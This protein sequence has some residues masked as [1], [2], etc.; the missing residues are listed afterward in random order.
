MLNNHPNHNIGLTQRVIHGG[1]W[2]LGLRGVSFSISL[3]KTF[4]LARILMPKDF[5]VMGVAMIAFSTVET[6]SQTGIQSALIQKKENIESYLNTAWTIS[7]IRGGVLFLLLFSTSYYFA[8]FFNAPETTQIIKIISIS[9]LIS[10]ITNIGVIYFQKELQFNKQFIYEIIASIVDIIIV[11]P[12][13]F[14]LKSAWALAISFIISSASKLIVSY[15]LCSY[16]PRIQ[17]EILKVRKLFQYGRWVSLS[18]VIVYLIMQGDNIFIS[19]IF[20]TAALGYYAMAYRI[21]NLPATEINRVIS[22]V[23]FPAYSKI[24]NDKKAFKEGFKKTLQIISFII[25]PLAGSIFVFSKE[26]TIV[27]LGK[28]WQMIIPIIQILCFFGV[29][30]AIN[31]TMGPALLAAGRPQTLSFVSLIQL[32]IM[33]II[34]YP[35]GIK[36]GI[37]GV[38]WA[39]TIANFVAFVIIYLQTTRL[40]SISTMEFLQKIYLS[41][42]IT[43]IT[44]GLIFLL[45]LCNLDILQNN[46]VI[47]LII[48]GFLFYVLY[49][50]LGFLFNKFFKF[51]LEDVLSKNPLKVQEK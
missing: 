49:L 26:I 4:I 27:I 25:M 22:S 48:M 20:G 16:R 39:V 11:V 15:I 6:F 9:F 33:I 42:L 17:L 12:A 45:K 34:M 43:L 35:L 28:K 30:R 32:I 41:I 8:D 44:C 10:G 13:A 40:L 23:T 21:A 36:W 18:S 19:K 29:I 2:V 50:G 46:G 1:F 14:I 37:S 51:R 38:A 3:I 47:Q 7:I 5:G 31:G 24:Q